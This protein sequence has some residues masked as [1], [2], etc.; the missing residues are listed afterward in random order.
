MDEIVE[1]GKPHNAAS[2]GSEEHDE[3]PNEKV[4]NVVKI[5]FE[6]E[7]VESNRKVYKTVHSLD[8]E[9]PN[10]KCGFFGFSESMGGRTVGTNWYGTVRSTDFGTKLL[11]VRNVVRN[12]EQISNEKKI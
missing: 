1:N 3:V 7:T 11:L 2:L 4:Q 12:L 6:E 8:G 10:V 9:N 5:E